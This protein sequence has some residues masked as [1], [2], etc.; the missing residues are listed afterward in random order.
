MNQK[1]KLPSSNS[2]SRQVISHSAVGLLVHIRILGDDMVLETRLALE[3][4]QTRSAI[5][6]EALIGDIDLIY[7]LSGATIKNQFGLE[8]VKFHKSMTTSLFVG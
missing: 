6:V 2:S 8:L 7:H 1:N 5:G 4:N 3:L